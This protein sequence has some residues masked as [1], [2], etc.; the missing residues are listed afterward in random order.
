MVL[1]PQ[2]MF[3][4]RVNWLQTSDPWWTTFLSTLIFLQ[5]NISSV[6]VEGLT[7]RSYFYHV[8]VEKNIINAGKSEELA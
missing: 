2:I 8:L 4:W 7:S 5:T 1:H 6:S 3:I